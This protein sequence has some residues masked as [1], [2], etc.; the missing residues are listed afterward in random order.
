[1]RSPALRFSEVFRA[2]FYSAPIVGPRVFE[3]S[4]MVVRRRFAFA[5]KFAALHAKSID[6]L[7]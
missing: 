7:L 5:D 3:Q 2:N 1:M 4:G 6:E